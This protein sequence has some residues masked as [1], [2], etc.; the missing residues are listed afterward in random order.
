MLK[1]FL[2][3]ITSFLAFYTNAQEPKI[4]IQKGLNW[5]RASEGQEIKF[6]LN[7]SPDSIQNQF[8]FSIQQGKII[9]MNLDSAAQFS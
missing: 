3:I 8:K 6:K 1:Y 9:G 2:T 5:N 7:I 4:E